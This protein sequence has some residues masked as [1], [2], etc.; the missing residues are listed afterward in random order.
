[1]GVLSKLT[2]L[3]TN[4]SHSETDQGNLLL[5]VHS[6]EV[7]KQTL[8]VAEAIVGPSQGKNVLISM[9]FLWTSSPLTSSCLESGVT[10]VVGSYNSC[11][12]AERQ[13]NEILDQPD[14]DPWDPARGE[15]STVA[16]GTL[17]RWLQNFTENGLPSLKSLTSFSLVV[18]RGVSSWYF[19]IA[20]T[21]LAKIITTLPHTCV[22]LELAPGPY[23]VDRLVP[24]IPDPTVHMCDELRGLLPRMRHMR[25]YL[26]EACGA[27]VGRSLGSD[28]E[29]VE[30]PHLESLIVNCRTGWRLNHLCSASPNKDT[31]SWHSVIRA[32]EHVVDTPGFDPTKT[33]LL[34]L[35]VVGA[36]LG[37]RT[38]YTTILRSEV[39]RRTTLAFPVSYVVPPDIERPPP[40]YVRTDLGG[41]I[42]FSNAGL[43]GITEG[44][45]WRTLTTGARLPDAMARSA[46]CPT[47]SGEVMTEAEWRAKYPRKSCP[48]WRNEKITGLNLLGVGYRQG[49][50]DYLKLQ[51]LVEMTP[52]GWHRQSEDEFSFLF[53]DGDPEERV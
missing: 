32:L 52:E 6:G 17:D 48:L 18:A 27:L 12:L 30:L 23:D 41:F 25:I 49:A 11:I 38:K 46:S 4:Q 20:R 22:N 47:D 24:E 51:G 19:Q 9:S 15:F 28:F 16:N 3:V 53:E 40:W 2:I 5:G 34:V 33:K 26:Q 31:S 35:G 8:T 45:P 37:D 44:G 36:P 14:L 39:H 29:A 1:M 7:F 21:T 43:P 50:D 42:S 13:Q 10:S